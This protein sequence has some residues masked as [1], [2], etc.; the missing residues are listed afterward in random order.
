MKTAELASTAGE[1]NRLHAEAVRLAAESELCLRQA[2]AAAWQA[3]RLLLEEKKRVRKTMGGGAWLIWLRKNFKGTPRTAQNYMR[4][5]ECVTDAAFLQGMSL[6]QTYL[7]LGIAT[8]PK[9]PRQT[10]RL[11]ELPLHVRLANRLLAALKPTNGVLR[12]PPAERAAYCQD[13]RPLYERLR[14]LFEPSGPANFVDSGRSN[15]A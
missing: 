14:R 12:A 5:A 15:S 4:L 13:L 10:V 8:E 3:G 2:L 6:R 11:Q 1:I 7:R 9:T